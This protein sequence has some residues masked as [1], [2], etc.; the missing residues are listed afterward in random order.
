M[1]Q[2]TDLQK[3]ADEDFIY[4]REREWQKERAR[5]R[6]EEMHNIDVDRDE[7]HDDPKPAK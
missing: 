5:R 6:I 2:N 4:E 3:E 1:K 7:V